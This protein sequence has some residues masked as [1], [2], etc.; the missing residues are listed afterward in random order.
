MGNAVTKRTRKQAGVTLISLMIGLLISM[1]TV[2][3]GMTLYKNLSHINADTKR[4][5]LHD[6][7]LTTVM[8][9]LQKAVHIAGYGIS[10][11]GA[12]HIATQATTNGKQL[13]WRYSDGTNYFC[14]GIEDDTVTDATTNVE[15]RQISFITAATG[16]DA[17]AA[18][19]GLTWSVDT[20]VE[21]WPLAESVTLKNYI[22]TN[23]EFFDFGVVQTNCAPF[24]I[25]GIQA[26]YAVTISAPDAAE[27]HG[28]NATTNSYQY[29]LPNLYVA[30]TP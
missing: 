29:C 21:R 18:L 19:T 9:R 11:A 2:L 28:A 5:T 10:S 26:R 6:G 24:G 16:C 25:T 17:T 30:A 8:L 4:D 7:K 22:T 20:I 14:R 15:Y 23:A 1:L 3:S 27:L 13:L 12:D